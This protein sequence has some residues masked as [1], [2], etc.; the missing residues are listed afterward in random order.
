MYITLLCTISTML[1][2]VL[3]HD[4]DSVHDGILLTIKHFTKHKTLRN[5][6]TNEKYLKCKCMFER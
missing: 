1:L 3:F 2:N 6:R 5:V 4:R